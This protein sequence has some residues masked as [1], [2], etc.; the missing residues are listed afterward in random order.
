M[1]EWWQTIGAVIVGAV[2]TQAMVFLQDWFK[3]GRARTWVERDHRRDNLYELQLEV[4][5]MFESIGDWIEKQ[6]GGESGG[7]HTEVAFNARTWWV[8]SLAIRSADQPLIDLTEVLVGKAKTAR[9]A[10][11]PKEAVQQVDVA[12]EAMVPFSERIALLL[13]NDPKEVE[14]FDKRKASGV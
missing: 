4:N 8:N 3:T 7:S 11:S 13:H 6:T 2:L 10:K 9:L 14:A 5:R 12:F 1:S